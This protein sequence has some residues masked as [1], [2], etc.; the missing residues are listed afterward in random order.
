MNPSAFSLE[1]TNTYIVGT[2]SRRL[3]VDTGD[4]DFVAKYMPVLRQA[5]AAAGA[6]GIEQIVLTHWHR[7]HIGGAR[8]VVDAFGPGITVR[9]FQPPEGPEVVWEGGEGATPVGEALAGLRVA[10][11]ADGEVLR[12]EGATL[13]AIHTP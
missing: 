5:L 2:G 10:P 12:V 11:V 4:A 9:R 1:G 3:L 8:A 6:T 13:R 7:D